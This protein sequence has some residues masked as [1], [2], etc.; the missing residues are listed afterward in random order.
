MLLIAPLG[1]RGAPRTPTHSALLGGHSTLNTVVLGEG[2]SKYHAPRF[3][4]GKSTRKN[5][6]FKNM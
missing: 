4:L 2:M 3:F 1:Y 5:I 6:N